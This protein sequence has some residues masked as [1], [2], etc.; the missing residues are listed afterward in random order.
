M[1]LSKFDNK[2][3]KIIDTEDTVF[4]GYA[5]FND[6][7]YN[8]HEYGRNEDS[9]QIL[10]IMF[11]ESYI[12]SVEGIKEF[13]D[14]YGNLE[15]L[16]CDNDLDFAIDALD[17]DN[18]IHNERIKLYLKDNIDKFKDKELINKIINN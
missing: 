7:E 17:Y 14:K 4:E 2:L 12:K 8:Y 10:N 1:N 13:S 9:L 5:V 3:V 6:K 11:Y 16:I 15:E 18:K